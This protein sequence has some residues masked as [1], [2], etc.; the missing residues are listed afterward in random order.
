MFVVFALFNLFVS[1]GKPIGVVPA[2]FVTV[3]LIAGVLGEVVA[4][5]VSDPL[6]HYFRARWGRR[7]SSDLLVDAFHAQPDLHPTVG[8]AI[9][10]IKLV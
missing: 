7:Y 4:R 10:T 1:V 6:N 3:I 8:K 2:L 5:C 9:G